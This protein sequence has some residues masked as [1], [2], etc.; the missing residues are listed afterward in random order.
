[1]SAGNGELYL[2]VGVEVMSAYPLVFGAQMTDLFARLARSRTFGQR[3]A[4]LSR[5]RPR[6]LAP[7]IALTEGLTDPVSGLIMGRTAEVLARE[8][9]I[10]RHEQ[11]AYAAR[12]HQR[13]RAARDSGRL[14]REIVPVLPLGARPG[15]RALVHDDGIRDDESVE[16]LARLKP[17][18][19]RP[20]GTV[21]VGNSLP[22]TDGA[23]A[24][25]V[26]TAERARAFGLRPLAAIRAYAITGCDPARMGLGPVF[27]TARALDAARCSFADIG[28]IEINE[29]F[30][31]QVLACARAFES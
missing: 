26:T 21:T 27:A 12:S 17:Y 7:R 3:L 10:E 5:F 16:T 13:A 25:L 30:A 29:A 31:A 6:M 8:F 9:G 1:I 11:D 19:E 15:A 23:A 2:C 28:L 24:L 4:A 22:I 18:F 20:D 14:A